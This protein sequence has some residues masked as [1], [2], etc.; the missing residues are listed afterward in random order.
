MPIKPQTFRPHGQP[1]RAEQ[2]QHY[3]K[4][5]G[6]VSKR[7]PYQTA[8]WAATRKR[9][10]I[11]DNYQCVDCGCDVGLKPGDFHCEHN[12]ERPVGAPINTEEWD[13]DANL[14]TRC[15]RCSNAKT[16]RYARGKRE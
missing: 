11:R 8:W 9:I 2:R 6:N 10:A 7:G 12:H 4:K 14:V 15:Q 16:G 1:T 5:R 3:D 13:N